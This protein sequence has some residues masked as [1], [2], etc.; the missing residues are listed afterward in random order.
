[1]NRV[2]AAYGK[3]SGSANR[4]GST[5]LDKVYAQPYDKV[6]EVYNTSER[7]AER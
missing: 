3:E 6:I 4:T 7:R 5:R 1:M 2:L